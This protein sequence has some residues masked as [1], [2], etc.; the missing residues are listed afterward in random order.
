[1]KKRKGEDGP[2]LVSRRLHKQSEVKIGRTISEKRERMET[3]L[4]RT[5]EWKKGKRK[6]TVRVLFV[7]LGFVIVFGILARYMWTLVAENSGEGNINSGTTTNVSKKPTVEVIDL[8]SGEHKI[9]TRMSEYIAQAEKDWQ[10]LGYKPIRVEIPAGAIRQVNFFLE[11]VEGYI[12][13]TIDRDSAISVEDG[14]RM[15]RYLKGK[16]INAFEY[17]DVR[18][19][20]KGYYKL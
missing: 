8:A 19:E 10:D 11:G 18:V 12:K 6:K 13:M 2:E 17:I 15:I 4:E 7:I 14:D 5:K 3:S 9:T 16:G 1:M 20:K